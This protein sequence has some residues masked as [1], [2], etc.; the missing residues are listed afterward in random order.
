MEDRSDTYSKHE[1]TETMKK[2]ALNKNELKMLY[3]RNIHEIHD[4]WGEFKKIREKKARWNEKNE[5]GKSETINLKWN[6]TIRRHEDQKR[7]KLKN[8]SKK[9]LLEEYSRRKRRKILTL[10]K[11]FEINKDSMK[12]KH[13]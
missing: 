13:I 4:F 11:K 12:D 9:I 3:T 10:K 5:E 8:C 2:K 6:L 7:F 1:K